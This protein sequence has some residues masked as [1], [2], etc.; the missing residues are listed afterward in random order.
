MGSLFTDDATTT[1]ITVT[2][3]TQYT[4]RVLQRHRKLNFSCVAVLVISATV[5]YFLLVFLCFCFFL[6]SL[7]FSGFVICCRAFP[8]SHPRDFL[9]YLVVS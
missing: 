5:A 4:V 1:I 3:L 8:S 6:F 9:V 2:R 7:F